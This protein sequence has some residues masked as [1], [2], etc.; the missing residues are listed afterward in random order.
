MVVHST[1][2]HF[3]SSE[4]PSIPVTA[5]DQTKRFGRVAAAKQSRRDRGYRQSAEIFIMV[6][7]ACETHI[8]AIERGYGGISCETL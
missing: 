8:A 3:G 1:S 7:V 2:Q 4:G 6:T 5:K